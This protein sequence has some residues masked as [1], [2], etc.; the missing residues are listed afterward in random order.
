MTKRRLPPRFGW[1]A[2]AFLLGFI[3]MLMALIILIIDPGSRGE[4]SDSPAGAIPQDPIGAPSQAIDI[5]T[6]DD[7]PPQLKQL[8]EGWKTDWTRHT[9]D[10]AEILSGGPPRDGIPSIDQPLFIKPDVA[11]SWLK[12]QEPVIFFEF[13]G[14]KRAYP[15]Q[16]LLWHEIVN[17]TVA[18]MPVA[19]T[20]C[21]LCN[22][23]AV[24]DRRIQGRVLE[25]GVSGLLRNSDLIMYDRQTESLWQQFTGEGIVGAMAGEQLTLLPASIISFASFRAAHP[26]GEVL[27]RETGV[28]RPY[29]R[30]PYVGYDDIQQ[31]P[32]LFDAIPDDRLPPMERVV[33][34]SIMGED[35]AYPYSI[36]SQKRI[37]QD[38]IADQPIVIFYEPNTLS[39]L[40]AQEIVNSKMVGSTGVFSAQF[41]NNLLTF[42]IE[43]GMIVDEQTRSQWNLLG[44]AVKG[45]L[46][47]KSLTP[48]VHADHFWFSWAAF[49]PDTRIFHEEE[50]G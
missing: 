40:D 6:E 22:A 4:L 38:R 20:F 39:A 14:I 47:G 26:K 12:D 30:N 15:L 10:Y 13:N 16:I 31:S 44:T 49:K 48:I 42:A 46:A 50:L 19:V 27:S 43:N 1:I 25:F 5:M 21:P 36:L 37:I 11:K 33:T 35:V 8:T 2:T 7:R 3:L 23:A 29:G 17:D 32:F 41:E 24:F 45:P 18:G 34:V 9:I 28:S